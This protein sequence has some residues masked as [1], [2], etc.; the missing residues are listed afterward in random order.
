M[1][2]QRARRL[3]DVIVLAT[4]NIKGGVGKTATAVNLAWMA[5]RDGCSTLVWDLDPQGAATFYFRVKPK[6]KGGGKGL[7]QGKHQLDDLIKAT[8]FTSLDLLP[9][10]FSY[11]HLDLLLDEKKKPTRQ[12]RKLLNP[13]ADEYDY[14]IL[15]CPPSI[16]LVSEAVFQAADALLV[17]VIPTTLSLRTLKQLLI[18]RREQSLKHLRILPFFSMVDR[19]KKL[20]QQ[21]VSYYPEKYKALLRT[22]IPYASDVERMGVHRAPLGSYAG[23]SRSALAYAELWQEVRA[24]LERA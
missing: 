17:P 3:D 9:A 2:K 4:Y 23:N 13:L 8:D 1:Q 24:R 14:V 18:F 12:L 5:A 16:S 21:I 15:D 22:E 11:R 19:R 10:D 6:I 7:L 20:H